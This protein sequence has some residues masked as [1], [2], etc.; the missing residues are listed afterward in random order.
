M[1]NIYVDFDNTIVESN[2]KIIDILNKKYNIQKTE[3]DLIDY[4]YNSIIEISEEEKLGMF[5]S[6]EFFSN[7]EFKDGFLDVYNKYKDIYNFIITTKGTE[8][9]LKKK[10]I[11]IE[12]NISNDI[13]FIGIDNDSFSKK[14]V[15]MKD[16]LQID[17]CTLALDTNAAIKILYKDGHN[18]IWQQGYEN[19]EILV[20]NSWKEID[21]ILCFYNKY[22]YKTLEIK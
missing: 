10:K 20:T 9:N 13:E 16:G 21:E 11:W 19:T 2:K 17:D 4:G 15:D 18:F 12:S 8:T 14:Q 7:L 1:V 5:A 22:D 6:D 3:N